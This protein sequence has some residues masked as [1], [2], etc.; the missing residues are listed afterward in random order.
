[1][2]NRDFHGGPH[3]ES[4]D[5]IKFMLR[6]NAADY[7]NVCV[8]A[9]KAK[10]HPTGDWIHQLTVIRP[11]VGD[12]GPG[13]EGNRCYPHVQLLE[14]WLE[15]DKLIPFIEAMAQN[16]AWVG[17]EQIN[18]EQAGGFS[19]LPKTHAGPNDYS[20][21]PGSLLQTNGQTARTVLHD[22]L[23][24]PG[25]PYY[26]GLHEAL[27]EWTG[28]P[29]HRGSDS[30]MVRLLVFMPECRARIVSLVRQEEVI[31]VTLALAPTAPGDLRLVGGW[32]DAGRWKRFD[33]PAR[34][35]EPKVQLE[36]PES[37]EELNFHL[38]GG[39]GRWYDYHLESSGHCEGQARVLGY[40]PSRTADAEWL[41]Q[42]LLKGE[43]ESTEFK[44]LFREG[45][46]REPEIV[47]T[48]IAFLN[49]RGGTLVI[50]V[51]DLG[52]VEGIERD[53]VSRFPGHGRNLD[54]PIELYKGYVKKMCSDK[55]NRCPLLP[56][57]DIQ[58]SGHR[59]LLVE[60]PEGNEKI[61]Q[62][63]D[64]NA[65]FIRRGGTCFRADADTE[66]PEMLEHRARSGSPNLGGGEW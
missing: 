35:G 29:L 5:E 18:R 23:V 6:A 61:Y 17:G 25:L 39:D 26:P 15:P 58:Y 62:R 40:S 11:S 51:N 21:Y 55:M 43:D 14:E 20:L 38:I 34:H 56:M 33:K 41:R 27:C 2:M 60:V 66:I 49:K 54:Q 37:A 57:R 7:Q 52:Q 63:T 45:D 3:D 48:I 8:R 32:K 53:L 59:V 9:V 30:R 46:A 13:R 10:A 44:P 22:P 42:A 64:D 50:G 12:D 19:T 24:S 28:I 4:M 31:E 47:E 1:M 16:Q 36:V 65:I